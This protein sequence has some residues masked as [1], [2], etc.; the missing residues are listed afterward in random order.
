MNISVVRNLDDKRLKA[1]LTELQNVIKKDIIFPD[2]DRGRHF[3]INKNA[4]NDIDSFMRENLKN[5]ALDVWGKTVSEKYDINGFY[6]IPDRNIYVSYKCFERIFGIGSNMS[7]AYVNFAEGHGEFCPGCSKRYK[8]MSTDESSLY[9]SIYMGEIINKL[10]LFQPT[11]K[12]CHVMGLIGSKIDIKRFYDIDPKGLIPDDMRDDIKKVF[13]GDKNLKGTATTKVK[14]MLE[15]KYC[16]TCF[17]RHVHCS[18][19]C[20]YTCERGDNFEG[21][22]C[23]YTNTTYD[24]IE[25]LAKAHADEDDRFMLIVKRIAAFFHNIKYVNTYSF[26]SGRKTKSYI[27]YDPEQDEVAL[28]SRSDRE[29]KRESRV[30]FAK[31]MDI[32]NWVE[33]DLNSMNYPYSTAYFYVN[34][35][36]NDLSKYFYTRHYVGYRTNLVYDLQIDS[37]GKVSTHS[38]Q[39]RHLV[40]D[41]GFSFSFN[42]FARF[43]VDGNIINRD[44]LHVSIYLLAELVK[45]DKGKLGDIK[46]KI[47]SSENEETINLF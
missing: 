21:T 30:D 28:F 3:L 7:I 38:L 43:L 25:S 36:K 39:S 9:N 33:P 16:N 46:Q 47:L 27:D 45:S 22:N 2:G 11:T 35:Y 17:M 42:T 44:N 18:S 20:T 32:R 37:D 24:E 41:S 4:F 15:S 40:G 14:K 26:K 29:V 10:Y 5:K 6:G 13:W 12:S 23:H 31:R 1:K 8:C 34:N 19:D